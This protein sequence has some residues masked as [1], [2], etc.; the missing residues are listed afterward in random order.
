M[1]EIRN[2]NKKYSDKITLFNINFNIRPKSIVGLLGPNG[3]G[4]TTFIRILA[5]IISADSGEIIFDKKNWLQH[6]NYNI[7]YLPEERGLYK[8]MKVGEHLLYLALMKGISYQQAKAAIGKWLNK[9][10]IADWKNKKIEQLSKG[11]Q[12]KVQFIGT[13]IHKPNILILDEPF[14]GLDPITTQE[15]G[16]IINE[17]KERGC[18]IVLS[19]H[20][21]DSVETFCDNVV[22]INKGKIVLSGGVR[23]IKERNKSNVYELIF[24][25]NDDRFVKNL[26]DFG[27]IISND[28]DGDLNCIRIHT[29]DK[30]Q[31]DTVVAKYMPILSLRSYTEILPSMNDIF[32]NIVKK[33]NYE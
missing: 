23:E 17:E 24:D 18:T 25:T 32:I 27:T 19:S 29:N 9:F 28:T 6:K 22:L 11:M 8:N 20:N 3:A 7:G 33:N 12:Q 5:G 26:M 15:I 2:L 21:M 4:K 10:N 30:K 1:L 14:S 16:V 13:V 31:L